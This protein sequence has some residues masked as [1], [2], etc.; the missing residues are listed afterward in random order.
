LSCLG[1]GEI[2]LEE[3]EW[4]GLST[5]KFLNFYTG[6][7]HHQENKLKKQGPDVRTSDVNSE[8]SVFRGLRTYV[9]VTHANGKGTALCCYE[10]RHEGLLVM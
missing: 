8:T 6:S 3:R 7:K 1:S 4:H 9:N 10:P 2:I 5:F